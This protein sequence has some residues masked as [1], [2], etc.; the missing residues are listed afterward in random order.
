MRRICAKLGLNYIYGLLNF[1][2]GCILCSAYVV[3]LLASTGHIR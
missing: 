1:T 2:A 3:F